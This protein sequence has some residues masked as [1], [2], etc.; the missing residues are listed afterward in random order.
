M[1]DRDI[2]SAKLMGKIDSDKD[3]KLSLEE[4]ATHLAEE[5]DR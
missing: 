3:E 5:S 2:L 1:L 4:I